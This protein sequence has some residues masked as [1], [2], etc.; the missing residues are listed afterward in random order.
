MSERYYENSK[1]S[2]IVDGMYINGYFNIYNIDTIKKYIPEVLHTYYMNKFFSKDSTLFIKDELIIQDDINKSH[3]IYT[4]SSDAC[5]G[6]C[7][8]NDSI[9]SSFYGQCPPSIKYNVN[10]CFIQTSNEIE[11]LL[12]IK[13]KEIKIFYYDASDHIIYILLK[14][15]YKKNKKRKFY[16]P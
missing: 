15:K 8:I 14:E 5:D 7:F 10:G 13:M 11:M 4:I 1:M 2:L 9:F 3:I 16:I 12:S 6:Y